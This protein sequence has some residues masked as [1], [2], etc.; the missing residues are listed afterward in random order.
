MSNSK[1]GT[2]VPVLKPEEPDVGSGGNRNRFQRNRKGFNN[3]RNQHYRFEGREPSLKGFIYD[4]TG[5]RNPDQFIKTTK[6]I[7]NYVGRTYTKF[8]SEFINA[9]MN[10]ELDDP[11]APQNPNPAD[12]V[13]FEI[14]KLDIKEH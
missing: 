11:E 1:E 12:Q 9:V 4:A 14:W 8:T 7:I 3:N 13:A 5:E 10:L 2:G 6:E